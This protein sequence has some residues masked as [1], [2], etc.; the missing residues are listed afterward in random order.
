MNFENQ[1]SKISPEIPG[2]GNAEKG[3]RLKSNNGNSELR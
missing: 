1:N 2:Q 3:R